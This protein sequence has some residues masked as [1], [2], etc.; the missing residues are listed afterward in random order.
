MKLIKKKESFRWNV[1]RKVIFSACF[2]T[3]TLSLFSQGISVK[4]RVTDDTGEPLVGVSIQ[5]KGTT[6]GNITDINGDYTLSNLAADAVLVFSYVGYTPQEAPVAGK[7][8]LDII[9]LDATLG[10]EEVVVVAYGVQKKVSVTGA[11]ASVQTKELKISSSTSLAN[12]LAGRITGLTSMQSVG[13][14]PGRDDA[15]M[16]LRGAATTN[17]KSPLILIDG[18]PRDNIRTIDPNEVESISVLKDASATSVFGVRGAN[19]VILIT[20]RRGKEGK[21]ELTIN[22]TQ[23][24]SA[25]SREPSRLHSTDYLTLRNQALIN[26]GQGSAVFGED[27]FAKYENPLLGLDPNDPDYER[28]AAVRRYIY[29]DHDWYRELIDRWS[30][31]TLVN[32]NLSG[33]TEKVSYFM[34]VGYLHQGGNLKTEPES[35]LGYDPSVKLDRYSFRSNVDYKI[36]SSLK[37]FLNLGTYIEGVNM[38]ATGAMYSNDQNWTIRDIFQMTQF[39]LPIS[40]GP[41]TIAGFGVEAGKPL[42]PTY[43]N[44]GHYIDRAPYEIINWRGYLNELRAN[45]NS[46]A[47]M[48]WDLGF[49]TK[50]LSIKGMIS[51]DSWS[52]TEMQGEYDNSLYL[53]NVDPNTDELTYTEAHS[54]TNALSLRKYAE[55][56]YTLNAQAS[57][58]YNRQF[59]LH[60][61]GG[62]I[63]VQRDYWETTGADI[64]F[65]VL[66]LAGRATYNYDTRYFGEINVGYNG[67]EQFAPKKRFGFFPAA[68]I[69]WALSNEG[70]L[71]ENP[72][73]TYLKLRGSI[74]KVGNDKMGD[75][76]FLYIDN[77]TYGGGGYLGSISRGYGINEG[78]LGNPNLTWEVATKYNA[79]VD[80]Q[81]LKDISVTIDVF[82]E[83]RSQ[84]LLQRRSVPV[85]QGMPLDNIPRVNMGEVNNRGYEIELSYNRQINSDLAIQAKG[86]FAYNRNKRTNVDEVPRDETYAYQTRET[87]YS[88]DQNWGYVIDWSQDGGYWTPEA[89]ADPNRVTYDFGV[90]RAGDFVYTDL[91]GDGVISDKDQAPIGYSNI[92]RIAWGASLNVEYK[93]FN[94]YVFFQGVG[95]YNTIFKD[96]GVYESVGRGTYF[97]YH[98]TAWTEERWRNGEEITYPALSTGANVNHHPNS[99][100]IMDR[101]FARFKNAEIGYTLPPGTLRALGISRMR[102]FLQGQNIF[103]WSP[104]FR[105][106]HLDPENDDSI[107]YPQTKMF[108]FGTNITF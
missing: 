20:T 83:D 73:L 100:F 19:G 51:Y 93:G 42:D 89:L 6:A 48:E 55:S 88:I 43:L 64:P 13:G 104:D 17:G 50:G 95:K 46:S 5:V 29:P 82:K 56:K 7:T 101:T 26:D 4:G 91:N 76:R 58:L 72:V 47:G 80:F 3:F 75:T 24:Y 39:V 103:T 84:I 1:L 35:V 11:V 57:I 105:A 60:D 9:L 32:A 68:S 79:G 74:G 44:S 40:P 69:G 8:T 85:W 98:R 92:P 90:P 45:L 78:L 66:G 12:A 62:M 86:N 49:I 14:Q 41:T 15:T 27:I 70:F 23:S 18:V 77:I 106:T 37:V 97:D 94:A 25:L 30:P 2:C 16:Y 36:S 59:N 107:G 102:V 54:G 28:K 96:Q 61:V 10:L 81:L 34:N 22:A 53:A 108:S 38:A 31:Q 67:S 33:G 52:K 99:F 63:L 87:G 21:P 65:N 71:K